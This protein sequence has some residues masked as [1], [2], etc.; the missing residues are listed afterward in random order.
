[1][2]FR[3]SMRWYV[4][5]S[6]CPSVSCLCLFKKRRNLRFLGRGD[7]NKPDL[8]LFKYLLA[9][10]QTSSLFSMSSACPSVK[11]SPHKFEPRSRNQSR[12]IVA[13]SA[14]FSITEIENVTDKQDVISQFVQAVK[15]VKVI[16]TFSLKRGDLQCLRYGI[17]DVG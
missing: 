6:V 5:P 11:R 3:I 15:V 7:I 16:Q 8:K 10:L 17:T 9:S 4:S 1:M 13:Q 2:R 12:R 14:L